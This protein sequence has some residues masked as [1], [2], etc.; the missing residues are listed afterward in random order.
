M[1]MDLKVKRS[2]FILSTC[3]VYAHSLLPK[4]TAFL[5][6]EKPKTKL[7]GIEY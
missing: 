5:E 6:R 3:F 4:L 2:S 1:M 7:K